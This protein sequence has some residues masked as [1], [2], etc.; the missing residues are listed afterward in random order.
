MI[1]VSD[2]RSSLGRRLDGSTSAGSSLNL[3]RD[4]WLIGSHNGNRS[5]RVRSRRF[6]AKTV[7][8]VDHKNNS[9]W[10]F[11]L[12]VRVFVIPVCQTTI[13]LIVQTETLGLVDKLVAIS[14]VL[15]I[16]SVLGILVV[17]SVVV[18]VLRLVVV[19]LGSIVV[20]LGLVV[21]K[22][23][24]VLVVLWNLGIWLL[25]VASRDGRLNCR[26]DDG[27]W[28]LFGVQLREIVVLDGLSGRKYRFD[29]F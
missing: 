19:E 3:F 12:F 7:V 8:S 2:R 1:G 9:P 6:P 25:V 17:L 28:T 13:L 24:I 20:Q 23:G 14:I 15:G 29:G 16:V 26:H 11:D 22:L 4:V 5:R 10:S 18:S 27:I 21:G